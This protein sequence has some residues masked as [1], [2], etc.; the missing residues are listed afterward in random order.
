M[1]TRRIKTFEEQVW[2]VT[3]ST[4]GSSD[5]Y[6]VRPRSAEKLLRDHHNR[7]RREVKKLRLTAWRSGRST[8]QEGKL[9]MADDI[10][11][12]LDRLAG[13]KAEKEK[14]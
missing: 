14:P 12:M 5:L 2:T 4:M 6:A 1:T 9:Q 7:I 11:A 8:I 10:L 13:K 3:T